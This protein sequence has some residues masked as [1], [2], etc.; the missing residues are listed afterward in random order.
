M[1]RRANPFVES[2]VVARI[3]VRTGVVALL[4]LAFTPGESTISLAAPGLRS[5]HVT[6]LPPRRTIIRKPR[7]P[8]NYCATWI[9]IDQA[10]ADPSYQTSVSI[11]VEYAQEEP[12]IDNGWCKPVAGSPDTSTFAFTVNGVNR[13]SY[14]TV[15]ADHAV[16]T[17]VPLADN[18]LNTLVASITGNDNNGNHVTNQ[19]THTTNVATRPA[20]T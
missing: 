6:A 9:G 19:D 7:V 3:L 18:Q 4:S 2:V 17:N 8:G 11:Y 1:L 13:K 5:Q 20:P 15:Y 16:G 14:F 12:D 10:P